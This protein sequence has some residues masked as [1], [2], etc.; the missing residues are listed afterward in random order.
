[1]STTTT[2]DPETIRLAWDIKAIAD[3]LHWS[4]PREDRKAIH[5]LG[6]L[7]Y[8]LGHDETATAIHAAVAGRQP[9]VSDVQ[10]ALWQAALRLV[11]R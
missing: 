2:L 5:R 8:A 10:V 6:A 9:S 3:R 4:L 7:A 11:E 1:M